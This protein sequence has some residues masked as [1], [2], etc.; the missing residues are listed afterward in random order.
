MEAL[1]RSI[2]KLWQRQIKA[3]QDARSEWDTTVAKIRR[4]YRTPRMFSTDGYY[5]DPHDQ[6][7]MSGKAPHHAVA[8]GKVGE[9]VRVMLPWIAAKTPNRLVTPDLP[10]LSQELVASVYP[11]GTE[12]IRQQQEADLQV[13]AALLS[14]A[15]GYTARESVFNFHHESRMA[16]KDMLLSGRGILWQEIIETPDGPL[17]GAFYVPD[18][19]LWFDPAADMP[20]NADYAI[21][22]RERPVWKVAEERG[23]DVEELLKAVKSTPSGHNPTEKAVTDTMV[24]YEVYSRMGIGHRLD[25]QDPELEETAVLFDDAGDYIFLEISE[26]LDYPL[27]LTTDML[28]VMD[29]EKIKDTLHWPI[30]IWGDY[31]DPWPFALLDP[32][33]EGLYPKPPL[34]DAL[35]LI[36]FIDFGWGWLMGHIKISARQ[37]IIIAKALGLVVKEGI[38]EGY[39]LEVL[40]HDGAP[41]IDIPK[42][43]HVLQLP[44]VKKEIFEI[45]SGADRKLEEST[46]MLEILTGGSPQTQ[47]RSAAASNIRQSNAMIR[48]QDLAD[49]V[50]SFHSATAA[51]NGTA[52]RLIVREKSIAPIFGETIVGPTDPNGELQ[53]ILAPLTEKWKALLETDKPYLASADYTY[54]IEAGSGRRKNREKLRNDTLEFA[55]IALPI[56]MPYYQTTGDATQLNALM[57]DLAVGNEVNPDR[58]QFPDRQLEMMQAAALQQQQGGPPGQEG[59]PGQQP[60]ADQQGQPVSDEQG[61]MYQ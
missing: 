48:P 37:I 39:D 10:A 49:Q 25:T 18:K 53:P 7:F 11:P 30:E 32:Y 56:F 31:S 57:A 23:L 26:D 22:R 41:G 9:F 61:A 52:F 16:C 15:V 38:L 36:R 19:D 44:E 42:M 43:V 54:T 51:K 29:R 13:G 45:L 28:A 50:E 3:A 33:P 5:N 1:L 58:Y 46:G 2:A 6:P 20:R 60:P 14:H 47:D 34:E 40:E 4:Y 55:K 35:P 8:I 27:N 24:Y 21:R 12:I 17:P 59:P